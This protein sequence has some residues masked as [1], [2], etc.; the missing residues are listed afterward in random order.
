MHSRVDCVR[1][2]SRSVYEAALTI[3]TGL[4]DYH[5]ESVTG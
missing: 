4:T 2:V 3:V 1:L 5:L